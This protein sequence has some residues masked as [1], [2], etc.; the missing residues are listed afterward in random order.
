MDAVSSIRRRLVGMSIVAALGLLIA[1][2]A[3]AGHYEV[4]WTGADGSQ[5][6]STIDLDENDAFE[7]RGLPADQR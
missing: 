4:T 7:G 1:S 5:N 2:P 3:C 6:G